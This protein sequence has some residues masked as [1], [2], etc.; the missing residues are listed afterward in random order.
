VWLTPRPGRSTPRN[1]LIPIVQGDDLDP[2]PVLNGA[3][4]RAAA[5]IQIPDLPARNESLY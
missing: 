2:G 5:R 4:N 1:Y 3:E